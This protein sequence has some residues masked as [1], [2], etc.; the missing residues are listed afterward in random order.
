MKTSIAI[1]SSVLAGFCVIFASPTDARAQRGNAGRSQ[2][3]SPRLSPTEALK[4]IMTDLENNDFKDFKK[5][6]SRLSLIRLAN[7]AKSEN[8]T[9]DDFL[10]KVAKEISD[11]RKNGQISN[12]LETRDEHI[13]GNNAAVFMG[14]KDHFGKHRWDRIV[15]VKE[16]GEWKLERGLFNW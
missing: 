4:A 16:H 7:R 2:R 12:P 3:T 6:S 11:L 8:L 15:F 1:A 5:R 9:V 13:E 14:G 10:K